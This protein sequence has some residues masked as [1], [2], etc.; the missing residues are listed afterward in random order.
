VERNAERVSAQVADRGEDV[1]ESQQEKTHSQV[2]NATLAGPCLVVL[3]FME[4]DAERVSAHGVVKR[5]Q[6]LG[7]NYF[8]IAKALD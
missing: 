7:M 3:A 6:G 5:Q 8:P 1:F 2:E 4:R